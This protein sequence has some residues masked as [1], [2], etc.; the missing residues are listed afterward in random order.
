MVEIKAFFR[1]FLSYEFLVLA[2]IYKI[3]TNSP[4]NVRPPPPHSGSFKVKVFSL[5]L[6]GAGIQD[7]VVVQVASLSLK[8]PG[9]GQPRIVGFSR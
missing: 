9:L 7:H 6:M 2:F 3:Q 1:D 5:Q 4:P 8:R